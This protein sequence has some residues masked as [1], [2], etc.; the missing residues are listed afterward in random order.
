MGDRR[1]TERER[2]KGVNDLS[3]YLLY[4]SLLPF[5]FFYLCCSRFGLVW[6]FVYRYLAL[7][8]F[9]L[10]CCMYHIYVCQNDF[11]YYDG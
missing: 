6:F 8:F 9:C 4:T 5:F 7:G 1:G 11:N 3:I 2:G 10:G